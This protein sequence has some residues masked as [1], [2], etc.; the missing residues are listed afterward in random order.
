MLELV[1]QSAVF[2]PLHFEY[3]RPVIRVGRSED[4]DLV[5]RHPSIAPHH[6]LLVF[7][8]EKVLCLPPDQA[9]FSEADLEN[10]TGPEFDVGSQIRIGELRFA[11][12]HS[13]QTVAIPEAHPSDGTAMLLESDPATD[14]GA[15]AS[16][17]RY[18]C[19]HCQVFV[20]STEAKTLGLVGHAK[21]HLCP[22]CSGV[23]NIEQEPPKPS[24]GLKERLRRAT[25]KL[26]PSSPKPRP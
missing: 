23:L 18:F 21:R 6:C 25:R 3:D 22:K 17:G 16:Q 13:A 4:N 14:T 20:S 7:R 5:L 8:G 12:T 1:Y 26:V 11:L 19:A 15:A 9:V 10:L 24:P 2:G